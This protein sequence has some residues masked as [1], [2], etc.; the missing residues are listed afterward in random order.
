MV[1]ALNGASGSLVAV[2]GIVDG[3]GGGGDCCGEDGVIGFDEDSGD[4]SLTGSD[5]GSNGSQRGNFSGRNGSFVVIVVV[6]MVVL[7][8]AWELI[9]EL[10]IAIAY[11]YS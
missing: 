3:S 2:V 9:F 5:S 7:V 8:V 10:R 1:A 4:S 6:A 11:V